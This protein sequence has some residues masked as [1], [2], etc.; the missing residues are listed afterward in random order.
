MDAWITI[1]T[2]V[3]VMRIGEKYSVD[4]VTNVK[5]VSA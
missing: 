1:A 3:H 2:N 4:H 5:G